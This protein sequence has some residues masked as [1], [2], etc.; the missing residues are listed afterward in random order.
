[1]YERHT[2]VLKSRAV[3]KPE[4]QLYLVQSATTSDVKMVTCANHFIPQ[5]NDKYHTSAQRAVSSEA[6]AVQFELL[7]DLKAFP[8]SLFKRTSGNKM[9]GPV[10]GWHKVRSAATE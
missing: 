3:S 2:G 6:T 9:K 7:E 10:G 1:M 5:E 4:R 8:P